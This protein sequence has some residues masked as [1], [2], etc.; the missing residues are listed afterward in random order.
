MIDAARRLATELETTPY[1]ARLGLRAGDIL[2]DAVSASLPY[3]ATLANAQGFVHGGAAASLSM[4]VAMLAAVASDREG[5]VFAAPVSFSVGYLAAAREEDLHANGRI[6]SRGRD[7]AHVEIEV[8]SDRGRPVAAAQAV[9]RT[10]AARLRPGGPPRAP[11]AEAEGSARQMMS[12]FSRAMGMHLRS[13]E[14]GVATMAMPSQPNE[15]VGGAVDPAALVSLA[16]TCA[17]LACMPSLDE[18]R[19]GSATLSLSAV[20]GGEVTGSVVAMGRPVAEDAGVRS[21]LVEVRGEADP[22]ATAR[23]PRHA[24]LTACVSYRFR[25][26]EAAR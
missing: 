15:G 19:G 4:W 6:A 5:A 10:R 1:A 7:L 25:A 20:F 22:S 24:A 2:A 12:P 18:R 21:A 26:A 13:H 23:S 3:A 8:S 11:Q 14:Q 9:F 16:D 17:A